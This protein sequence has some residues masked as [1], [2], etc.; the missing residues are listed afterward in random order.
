MMAFCEVYEIK[1]NGSLV[2]RGVMLN[3]KEEKANLEH[4]INNNT[5]EHNSIYVA[6]FLEPENETFL[7][8]NVL[9]SLPV[10]VNSYNIPKLSAIIDR[11]K[12]MKGKER[13]S[14]AIL[15]L[16]SL[17]DIYDFEYLEYSQ[18]EIPN[19]KE[20][21]ETFYAEKL[22]VL[23]P[24]QKEM[25]EEY[26]TFDLEKFLFKEPETKAISNK[27]AGL[28]IVTPDKVYE[29]P[30]THTYHYVSSQIGLSR[31][32]N[33]S[34]Y[35]HIWVEEHAKKGNVIISVN[36]GELFVYRSASINDFQA[37]YLSELQR[38][39]LELQTKNGKNLENEGAFI[40][41]HN[42]VPGIISFFQKQAASSL[43]NEELKEVLEETNK[44][45]YESVAIHK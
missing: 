2:H 3:S 24:N 12:G 13:K 33:D 19:Y 1:D 10:L 23:K 38:K 36:P 11:L 40:Y 32:Y 35:M 20:A 18:N 4:I 17:S 39:V 42:N 41:T 22:N 27:N 37:K 43:T 31:H 30:E 21:I 6:I 15:N 5:F 16:R 34:T 45:Y 14:Y 26:R 7:V 29:L 9:T 8:S 25:L 28:I 44:N